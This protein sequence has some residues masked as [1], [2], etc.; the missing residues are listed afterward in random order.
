VLYA[1]ARR[2]PVVWRRLGH[3]WPAADFDGDGVTDLVSVPSTGVRGSES[4]LQR[5]A[6]IS[7]DDGHVLWQTTIE[8]SRFLTDHGRVAE[9]NGDKTADLVLLDIRPSVND[10]THASVV[11]NA[12]GGRRGRVIWRKE[13]EIP[14]DVRRQG[15]STDEPQTDWSRIT[16][17]TSFG[18]Q[19]N[20]SPRELGVLLEISRQP[21]GTRN[22]TTVLR[23]DASGG[24]ILSKHDADIDNE[25][26][27]RT[28]I[29]RKAWLAFFAD[30]NNSLM[31]ERHR[32]PA[33]DVADLNGDGADEV[34]VVRRDSAIEIVDGETERTYWRGQGDFF[35]CLRGESTRLATR[36]G[37]WDFSK[38]FDRA[39]LHRLKWNPSRV[40]E[41]NTGEREYYVVERR[42]A[43]LACYR[44][45]A[46][47]PRWSTTIGVL[48]RDLWRNSLKYDAA[49][50]QL[51][52]Q[53]G[54]ADSTKK[55][56]CIDAA[57]GRVRW[58][59][60]YSDHSEQLLLESSKPDT[61]PRTVDNSN[62]GQTI[63]RAMA[64]GIPFKPTH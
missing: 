47:L 33:F 64:G 22:V 43:R 44:P 4:G 2:Q 42:V 5:V 51:Y 12:V 28:A 17:A 20:E 16:V 57:T 52:V 6:A 1:T 3:W 11:L 37:I 60:D 21:G 58:E 55:A 8:A 32:G 36:E 23:F 49:S 46:E 19:H 25:T 54:D 14:A 9:L 35:A 61:P 38:G 59:S 18:S 39:E 40:V 26:D 62:S 31:R 34:V 53:F 7:G 41:G 63:A 30:R 24:R 10:E 15:V 48:E 13:V 56:Y 45:D 50:H 27:T 29:G